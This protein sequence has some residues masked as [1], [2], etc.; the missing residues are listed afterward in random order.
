MIRKFVITLAVCSLAASVGAKAADDG[1]AIY[2]SRCAV[3]HGANGEGKPAVK[4]PA[5]KGTSKD[6]DQ[7]IA[8]I[9]NGEPASK[10][11][12][13]KGIPGIT[14][15]QAKSIAQFIKTLP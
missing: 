6:V 4:A 3:C 7:L 14:E 8:H 1:A 2:K 10:P 11:P 9:T 5:L 13:N 15:E 12:H